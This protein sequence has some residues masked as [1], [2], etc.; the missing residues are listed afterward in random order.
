MNKTVNVYGRME[1]IGQFKSVS[2]NI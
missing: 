2:A 1:M